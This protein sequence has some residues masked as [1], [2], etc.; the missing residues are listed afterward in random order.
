MN[1]SIFS[2]IPR[3]PLEITCEGVISTGPCEGLVFH[4]PDDGF[5]HEFIFSAAS[6]TASLH[7]A[8]RTE[9]AAF[10]RFLPQRFLAPSRKGYGH[11]G[12][13]EGRCLRGPRIY[14]RPIA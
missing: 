1:D 7:R 14:A 4:V 13:F 10:L 5:V 11:S 9:A 3:G 6:G 2:G 8:Q 12:S